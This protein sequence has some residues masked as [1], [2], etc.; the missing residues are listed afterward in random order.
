M[1][2][3]ASMSHQVTLL[4]EMISVASEALDNQRRSLLHEAT[5]QLQRHQR[6][7]HEHLLGY[8]WTIRRHLSEVQQEVQIQQVASREEVETMRHELSQSLSARDCSC[9]KNV[10]TVNVHGGSLETEALSCQSAVRSLGPQVAQMSQLRIM[11]EV[12][13]KIDDFANRRS[14]P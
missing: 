11:L 12:E 14:P 3:N 1:G 4:K 13:R 8:Q 2:K 5:T 9:D 10:V 7:S 6:Q